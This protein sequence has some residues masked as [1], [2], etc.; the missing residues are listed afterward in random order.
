MNDFLWKL[1]NVTLLGQNRPRLDGISLKIVHGVTAVVGPSGA[2][3][4]SLL[5]LLTE[6]EK[7]DRGNIATNLEQGEQRLPLYWVPQTDGLW[8][9]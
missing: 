3:K 5:D 9:H 4:T 1:E 2:G 7:P 6:F 8:P